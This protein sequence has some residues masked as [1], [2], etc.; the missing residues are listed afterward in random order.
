[1][2]I[3]DLKASFEREMEFEKKKNGEGKISEEI[4]EV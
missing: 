3:Q 1:M 4:L 2:H